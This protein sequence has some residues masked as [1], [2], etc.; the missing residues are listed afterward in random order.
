MDKSSKEVIGLVSVL[1]IAGIIVTAISPANFSL[2]AFV[3]M[4]ITAFWGVSLTSCEN[5]ISNGGVAGVDQRGCPVVPIYVPVA[6]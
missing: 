1:G 5:G 3:L 6:E 2:E 4:P